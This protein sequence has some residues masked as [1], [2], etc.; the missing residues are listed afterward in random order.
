MREETSSSDNSQNNKNSNIFSSNVDL[1]A[2][3][4]STFVVIA[5]IFLPYS[6]SVSVFR[7]VLSIIIVIFN[8]GY[9]LTAALFPRKHDVSNIER[10]TLAFGLSI[11]I[12][13]LLALIL[14]YSGPI[15]LGSI[16]GV[17]TLVIISGSIIGLLRRRNLAPKD[18][19]TVEWSGFRYVTLLFPQEQS[20]RDRILS[21]LLVVSLLLSV[22]VVV[23]AVITPV[24]SDTYTEFY[25]LNSNGKAG[26]Y[27]TQF[28]L[29]NATPI[30]VGVVNHEGRTVTYDL[31]IAQNESSQLKTLHSEQF[32]VD[33]NGQ[34]EKTI[35]LRPDAA[36]SNIEFKFLLYEQENTT[37]PYRETHLFA[38]VTK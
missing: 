22:S 28:S 3:L 5:L 1:A 35:L 26:D 2:V 15:A 30:I 12:V 24:Q 20:R 21:I 13:P 31:V 29:A 6:S 7:Q 4:L 38:N 23:Y 10:V 25:I 36:G 17:L 8:P 19:F 27:P 9:A 14:A 34:W 32:N 33:D 11:A 37:S 18:R 16:V